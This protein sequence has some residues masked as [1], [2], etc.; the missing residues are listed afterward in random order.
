MTELLANDTRDTPPE[1]FAELEKLYGRPFRL[2]VCAT[3]DNTKVPG[4]YYTLGGLASRGTPHPAGAGRTGLTGGWAAD[5]YC[6]PPFSQLGLW[7]EKAW[8]EAKPGLMIVPNTKGEQEWWQRLVEP[9][10][11]GRGTGRASL[12]T[13][14]LPARRRFLDDGRPILNKD[15]KLGSPRFGLVAL[16]WAD[17]LR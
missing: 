9:F 12:T 6:N 15:G 2:D 13:H 10:R 7:V 4:C 3:H 16:I 8:S 11:D 14:F 17:R 1:L 5:W